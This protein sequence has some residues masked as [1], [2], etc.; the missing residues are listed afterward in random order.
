MKKR[1]RFWGRIYPIWIFRNSNQCILSSKRIGAGGEVDGEAAGD[2]VY[3]VDT[4]D[5]G[6]GGGGVWRKTL[7]PFPFTG[8]IIDDVHP[9]MWNAQYMNFIFADDVKNQVFFDGQA[10]IADFYIGALL[11]HFRVVEEVDKG[12]FEAREVFIGLR[13]ITCLRGITVNILNRVKGAGRKDKFITA[14]HCLMVAK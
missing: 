4:G 7:R 12:A 8:K 5:A 1:K 2:S 6:A 13:Y 11:A 10:A 9:H 3:A 14:R